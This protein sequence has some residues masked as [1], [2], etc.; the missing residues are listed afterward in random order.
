VAG[1]NMQ[2][3]YVSRS[4]RYLL[5]VG[6]DD[7]AMAMPTRVQIKR[8]GFEMFDWITMSE[9]ARNQFKTASRS[10]IWLLK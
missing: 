8:V 9:W 3:D 1:E 5:N 4:G 6:K 2:I 7:S 10:F